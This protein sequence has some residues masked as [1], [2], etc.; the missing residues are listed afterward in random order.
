LAR[1]IA[2]PVDVHQDHAVGVIAKGF[3]H[4]IVPTGGLQDDVIIEQHKV[5]AGCRAIACHVQAAHSETGSDLNLADVQAFVLKRNG[6]RV[7][8]I[9]HQDNF[10]L[11]Q[12]TSI[13][14]NAVAQPQQRVWPAAC[15][16][17]E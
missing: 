4:P 1:V 14:S 9:H 12:M 7:I 3:H 16:D 10:Q 5:L 8:V 2:Q 15:R 13:G 6:R 11:F 17:D